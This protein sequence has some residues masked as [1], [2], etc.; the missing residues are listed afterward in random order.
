MTNAE[1]Q[2]IADHHHRET[3]AVIRSGDREKISLHVA[4]INYMAR[5][6]RDGREPII[7]WAA[8]CSVEFTCKHPFELKRA[9]APHVAKLLEA[10]K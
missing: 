10:I 6:E 3:V 4:C 9:A 1:I 5:A 8:Q 2:R 7:T